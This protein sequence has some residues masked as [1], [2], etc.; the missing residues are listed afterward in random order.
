MSACLAAGLYGIEKGLELKTPETV[1]NGYEDL[2]AG[3]IPS[4]LWEATQAMK[5]SDVAKE[6]FGEGFVDHFVSTREWEWREFSKAV[7]DWELRRYFE[8]I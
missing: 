1:G 5:N 4:N 8:I 2:G 7:T 6:L 3:K